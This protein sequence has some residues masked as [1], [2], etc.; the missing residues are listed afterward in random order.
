VTQVYPSPPV[1]CIGELLI[2][3]I[4][5]DDATSLENAE[6][7]VARPG[8]APANVAVALA[9]LGVAS[10]FCGV[11]GDDP[12]GRRLR[13]ALDANDV[14]TSNLR[15][16]DEADTTIAFAWKNERGDG[17]FRLL[18]LADR[19]LDL[20]DINWANIESTGA[21]VVGSVSLAAEPSRFAIQHAIQIAKE[22]DVPI[23]VD[24]NIRP[25]MWPSPDAARELLS[26]LIASAT[27]LKLSVD[28]A[29]YLFATGDNLDLVFAE[30]NGL[31]RPFMVLTDGARGAW[32][33]KQTSEGPWFEHIPPYPVDAIEPTGAGD[34][35]TAAIISRLIAK[36][37]SALD[38]DDVRFAS[39]AG[40]LTT[41]R[42]GAIDSLPRSDEI[43]A[44]VESN[45]ADP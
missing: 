27:V 15:L 11:V 5:S 38:E 41:T 40:A 33:A 12:F 43:Q 6:S 14:G 17:E 44:F 18:R 9:R 26:P 2:D 24:V 21:I 7:F 37:W 35:F 23:C 13:N 31:A 1:L 36:G 29:R 10:A 4:A 28:D 30:L 16:T 20:K 8:G 3:F 19:L 39:A 34:A 25:S 45:V 42:T 22:E 32:F